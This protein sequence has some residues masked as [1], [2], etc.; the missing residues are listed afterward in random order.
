MIPLQSAQWSVRMTQQGVYLVSNLR[1]SILCSCLLPP[2]PDPFNDQ[3]HLG[4]V[5]S[6]Q[7]P[8]STRRDRFGV[9]TAGDR[10]IRTIRGP[11]RTQAS[12]LQV[13]SSIHR[14]SISN[15]T[16]SIVSANRNVKLSTLSMKT[17]S[18]AASSIA[19]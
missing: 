6:Y 7:R 3:T 5:S 18:T 8:D 14:S 11:T 19:A 1:P 13:R 9:Q 10:S 2:F 15:T 12:R 4:Q 17:P 16:R